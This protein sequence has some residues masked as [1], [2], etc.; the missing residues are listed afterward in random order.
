MFEN[1]DAHAR[2]FLQF[3]VW[4]HTRGQICKVSTSF[5]GLLLR[6]DILAAGVMM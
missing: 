1:H 2:K 4:Y 6:V 3:D 5:V